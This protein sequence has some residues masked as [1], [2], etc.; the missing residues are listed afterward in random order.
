M[1]MALLVARRIVGFTRRSRATVPDGKLGQMVHIETPLGAL[2]LTPHEGRNPDL[3]AMPKYPGAALV[4]ST[5]PDYE[6]SVQWRGR[7]RRF[8]ARLARGLP[9]GDR[10]PHV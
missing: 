4:T 2:D 1:I 8:V 5:T 6:A 10:R 3:A 7:N 9:P